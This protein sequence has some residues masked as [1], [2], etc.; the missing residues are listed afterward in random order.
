M[1][2]METE[3]LELYRRML[4]IRRFEEA[5]ARLY[6]DGELPGNVHLY[7]GEEAIAVGVCANLRRDDCV[8]STHRGHGHLIA[9]GGDVRLMMAELFG[10][11]TGYCRGKGG[12]MH[13][14]DFDL[15]IL[16][17]NGIVGGG[18]PIAVGAAYAARLQGIDRVT[19]A[20]F[21]DGASH[22]GTFH[23]SLNMASAWKL[24]VVFVCE[25]NQFGVSTRSSRITATPDIVRRAAAYNIPG[26]AI[27]GNDVVAVRAAAHDAV[28][29]ARTGHGPTLL[30]A[31]TFRT[32]GHFEGEV[33]SYWDRNEL[34]EW[35][36][37]DPLAR[38]AHRLKEASAADIAAVEA[39]VATAVEEAI[40]FGKDS[41][42]PDPEE[43]LEGLFAARGGHS[44]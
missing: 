11:R 7:V 42:F 17:A 34:A 10:K 3:L 27:D 24:P 1:G 5:V 43:A 40:R 25:N 38:L 13:I 36:A 4:T 22:E 9:K 20:F 41:P 15:G 19:A 2:M 44:P 39:E 16:G 18:L 14:A 12:S 32:R 21:G 35:K 30:V 31:D 8:T 37:R 23:E 26:V 29:L 33:I 28:A 6:A